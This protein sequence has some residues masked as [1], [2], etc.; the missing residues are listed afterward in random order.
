MGSGH[1]FERFHFHIE[2]GCA[3]S[4]RIPD[5]RAGEIPLTPPTFVCDQWSFFITNQ[6]CM[7]PSRWWKAC[8]L[9]F[10]M[11]RSLETLEMPSPELGHIGNIPA[12]QF[13]NNPHYTDQLDIASNQEAQSGNPDAS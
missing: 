10:T 13:P 8:S 5:F 9:D 3:Q 7:A 6:G 12:A 1:G 2:L 4:V 11:C